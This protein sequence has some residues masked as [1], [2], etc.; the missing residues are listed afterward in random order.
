[1]RDS[2]SLHYRGTEK[3]PEQAGLSGS[4]FSVPLCLSGSKDELRD[5]EVE[6]LPGFRSNER[7]PG[8]FGAGLTGH[9]KN[10]NARCASATLLLAA[11]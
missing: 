2:E 10:R 11:W 1:M 3:E 8:V 7:P 6:A 4:F 5:R 9:L